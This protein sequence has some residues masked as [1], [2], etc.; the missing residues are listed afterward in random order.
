M[1]SLTF[2]FF[3]IFP[4]LLLSTFTHAQN[5]QWRPE[6]TQGPGWYDSGG[7]ACSTNAQAAPAIRQISKWGAIATSNK[8]FNMGVV[9]GEENKWSAKRI[10]L[11]RCGASD[12]KVDFTYHDQCAAVAWGT[13]Y[14]AMASASTID[15][16]SAL[17]M[18]SCAKGA[19]DCKIVYSECSL[20]ELIQ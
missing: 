15:E 4:L 9:V 12:C 10:A 16:A 6:G 11:Q 13:R 20:P 3:N 17:A 1:K 2:K 5:C 14:S 18:K 8:T 19:D 7:S